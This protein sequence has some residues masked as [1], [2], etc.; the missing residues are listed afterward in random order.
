[1]EIQKYLERI[2]HQGSLA[3]TLQTLRAL[4]QAHLLAVPFE[5]LDIH[6]GREILLDQEAI[7][8]KVVERRRGGFCYELNSTFAWLLRALGFQVDL[9]SARVARADGGF[10]PEFDHLTLLVHLE[11]DWL[12]D[13][14]FGDSFRL[15]L[16]M[17]EGLIQEQEWGRYRLE[18]EQS[19][20]LMSVWT[21][22]EWQPGYHFTL[23]PHVL[24]NFSAMCRYH[25]TSPESHF[26]QKRVC[27][28]ATPTG[29]VTL[30]EQ[31][32]IVT[33]REE[34]TERLLTGQEAYSAAL[35]E[36]FGVVL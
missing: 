26:T 8:A 29:R 32:L 6:L 30:S 25:Q 11:E 1:M 18:Q 10:S 27:T 2:H 12:A 5:N 14:G 9:L 35:A 21:D 22:G 24:S 19:S 17:Q 7:L 15:P 28:I 33:T 20:W 16:R 31:R 34:R 3:P 13:V 23:Q 4:H 36:Y